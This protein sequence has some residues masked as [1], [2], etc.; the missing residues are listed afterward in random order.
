[1][2]NNSPEF[3]V[4]MLWA[5]LGSI[6]ANQ[7]FPVNWSVFLGLGPLVLRVSWLLHQDMIEPKVP[8]AKY[9]H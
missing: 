4:Y 9:R 8:N 2:K 7:W 1:M 6:A 3:L 5:L